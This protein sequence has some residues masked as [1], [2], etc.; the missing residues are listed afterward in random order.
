MDALPPQAPAYPVYGAAPAAPPP[1]A[2]SWQ[3]HYAA[4][5]RPYYHHAASGATQWEAPPGLG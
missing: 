2:A 3:V 4:D 1:A 5:G